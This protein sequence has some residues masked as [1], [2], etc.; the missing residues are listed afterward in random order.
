MGQDKAFLRLEPDGPMLLE[1]VLDRLRGVAGDVLIVAN[2]VKRHEGFGARV[3]PDAI[4]GFGT[5]SGIHAALTAAAHEHCLVVACDMPLLSPAVLRYMAAQRRDYDVL[6]PQTPGVSR[7][8]NSG[9]IYQT[10]HAIYAKR[11]A[12]PIASQLATG[13]RQVVGFFPQVHVR[14]PDRQALQA[15]DP[16]EL[17]FVN[18]NTPEALDAARETAAR[19]S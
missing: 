8:G 14:V 16:Q 18:T 2:D 11:C 10:L 19:N 15:L 5:L 9:Q 3:V 13:N 12:E 1:I 6:A 4:P 7:Q 17:T